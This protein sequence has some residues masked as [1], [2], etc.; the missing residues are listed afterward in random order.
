MLVSFNPKLPILI[1]SQFSFLK[2]MKSCFTFYIYTHDECNDLKMLHADKNTELLHVLITHLIFIT[3]EGK[4]K[5]TTDNFF[6]YQLK[7]CVSM[8]RS[9]YFLP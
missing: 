5:L 7:V 9:F 8:G 1:V 3:V 6:A 4:S 2:K